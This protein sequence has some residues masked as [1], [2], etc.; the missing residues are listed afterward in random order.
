MPRNTAPSILWRKERGASGAQGL[1]PH[2]R[3]EKTKALVLLQAVQ[4]VNIKEEHALILLL[5][6]IFTVSTHRNPEDRAVCFGERHLLTD[7]KTPLMDG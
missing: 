6:V 4:H 3:T 2:A 7:A 1:A 5:N